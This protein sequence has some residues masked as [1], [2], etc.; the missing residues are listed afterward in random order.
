MILA[1][2]IRIAQPCGN[3]VLRAARLPQG[4][5]EGDDLL[6]AFELREEQDLVDQP[7]SLDSNLEMTSRR[8]RSRSTSA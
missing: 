1:G 8:A 4:F 6:A 2:V 7:S 3:T 5:L